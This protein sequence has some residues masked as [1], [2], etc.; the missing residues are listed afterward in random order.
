M[1]NRAIKAEPMNSTFYD[2]RGLISATSESY[3]Q[4]LADFKQALALDPN[5]AQAY[6]DMG[7]V[8]QAL[9]KID[10]AIDSF[11]QGVEL[12]NP[13]SGCKICAYMRLGQ[14]Y[15]AQADFDRAIEAYTH[16]IE[17]DP[18]YADAYIERAKAY[19]AKGDPAAAQ[20]DAEKAHDLQQSGKATSY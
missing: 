3:D 14:L 19:V 12:E 4:A 20:A 16:A 6:F 11:T 18:N 2:F 7:A 13:D 8:Y 5:N 1:I 17:L 10:A 9:D 15:F